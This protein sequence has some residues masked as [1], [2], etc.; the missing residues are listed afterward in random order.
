MGR[1]SLSVISHNSTLSP[2]PLKINLTAHLVV[3]LV[4]YSCYLL[5]ASNPC[6]SLSRVCKTIQFTIQF[7][8]DMS[9]MIKYAMTVFTAYSYVSQYRF[10]IA[11]IIYDIKCVPGENR[12]TRFLLGVFPFFFFW[13]WVFR[14]R[15][16]FSPQ[17]ADAIACCSVHKLRGS[18]DPASYS[19]GTVVYHTAACAASRLAASL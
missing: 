6:S 7:T 2:P 3:P 12:H 5:V 8:S 19:S 13:K 11:S 18:S 10:G 15:I 9:R 17:T 4:L 1:C 16:D 14:I